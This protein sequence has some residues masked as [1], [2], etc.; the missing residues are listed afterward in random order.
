M[1]YCADTVMIVRGNL[2]LY[3]VIKGQ[4]THLT[5]KPRFPSIYL[6]ICWFVIYIYSKIPIYE[7]IEHVAMFKLRIL[8]EFVPFLFTNWK[9]SGQNRLRFTSVWFTLRILQLGSNHP[10]NLWK[11]WNFK[12]YSSTRIPWNS[13]TNSVQGCLW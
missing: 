13:S 4:V 12:I 9:Q 11:L 2:D 8:I 1:Q 6:D 3:S 10:W 7:N 5:I